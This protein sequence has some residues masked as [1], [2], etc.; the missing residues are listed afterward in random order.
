MLSTKSILAVQYTPAR[1]GF[2]KA[3]G[4]F[5]RYVQYRDHANEPKREQRERGVDA[6]V[7]YVAYRDA[8][9]PERR[10]FDRQR[11]VGDPQRKA[12]VRYVARSLESVK[13]RDERARAV[14][15]MVLSPEQA[16]GLDLRQ[17][18]R[19]VMEQLERDCGQPLPDWIAAEHRNTRHPHVHIVLPARLELERGR[20][21]TLVITRP[22]LA[23][24]KEAMGREIERQRLELVHRPSLEH[25]LLDSAV[26]EQE[27]R[28]RLTSK[29]QQQLSP[30]DPVRWER[31]RR[32]TP[33][34][35][36]LARR[37]E[38]ILSRDY[39]EYERQR[40]LEREREARQRSWGRER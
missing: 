3:V 21:R 32:R 31:A 34:W 38:R 14:Y 6:L 29:H 28:Q 11:T 37:W 33:T 36:K 2:R 26:R 27:R 7:R 23:R 1:G 30:L 15:R 39:E 18:T 16:R 35:K 17:V 9:S 40:Q 19:S 20:Y 8:A 10:L 24:M 22:R 5:L 12:L 13:A 4:G 25:R